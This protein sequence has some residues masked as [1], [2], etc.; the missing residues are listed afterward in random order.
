MA[1]RSAPLII[2]V[3]RMIIIFLFFFLS[4]ILFAGHCIMCATRVT[5]TGRREREYYIFYYSRVCVCEKT[6]GKTEFLPRRIVCMTVHFDHCMN[7][8]FKPT[9]Y[10]QRTCRTAGDENARDPKLGSH[11]F[12]FFFFR[13]LNTAT[14]AARG[15]L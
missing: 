15:F 9:I 13:F 3:I 4:P 7:I 5:G 2:V 12:F 1:I 11:F 14:R 6:I 8:P 10:K